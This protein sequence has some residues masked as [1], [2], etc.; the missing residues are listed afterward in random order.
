M[1]DE[2]GNVLLQRTDLDERIDDRIIK[3]NILHCNAIFV[4][5]VVAL[6]YSFPN[7]KDAII[8]EDWCL[9]IRLLSRYKL[10]FNK[11]ITSVITEHPQRSLRNID[12]DRLIASTTV[13]IDCLKNDNAVWVKFDGRMNY[14]FASQYTFI[15]LVLALT[16]RRRLE[17]IKFLIISMR[18]DLRIVFS[19]RFAASIKHL[20]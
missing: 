12:P 20:I 4:Q 14:F 3:D 16:K 2:A 5:R 15:T 13:I 17:T 6:K 11:K 8:A 7:H 19:R 10:Y 18:S 9:W 1:K